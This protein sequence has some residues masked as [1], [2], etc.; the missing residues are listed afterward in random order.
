MSY[1]AGRKI[2]RADVMTLPNLVTLVRLAFIPFFVWLLFARN[3]RG[4]AA[5]VLGGLGAT[6]WVDGWIARRFDQVSEFGKIFDPAVDRLMFLV[7]IP[8]LLIDGSVPIVVAV[9]ALSREAIV[10]V[11]ALVLAKAGVERFDVTWEGKTGAFLLM[12][13]FP[14]FLGANSELSYA[15]ILRP[16]AWIFVVPGLAYSYYSVLFQYVPMTR[17]GLAGRS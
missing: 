10:A 17:R 3:E 14:L 11:A 2:D 13:A 5:W 4:A 15:G 7:A 16:L 1:L 9:L 6:D 12:F 8:A